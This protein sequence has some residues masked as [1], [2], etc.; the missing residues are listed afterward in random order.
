MISVKP[1]ADKYLAKIPR[2]GPFAKRVAY[3]VLIEAVKTSEEQ[4][5]KI[6]KEAREKHDYL[7]ATLTKFTLDLDQGET[8]RLLIRSK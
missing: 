6:N 4:I 5:R 2:V 3:P 8:D 7:T 1:I